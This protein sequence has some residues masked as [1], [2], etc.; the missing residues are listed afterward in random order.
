MTP[1]SFS[2]TAAEMW[3][4][5]SRSR[6]LR[7]FVSFKCISRSDLILKAEFF[8]FHKSMLMELIHFPGHLMTSW[9]NT[10]KLDCPRR[11][12]QINF[13]NGT[14]S[15]MRKEFLNGMHWKKITLGYNSSFPSGP[16][17]CDLIVRSDHVSRLGKRVYHVFSSGLYI[18]SF[19]GIPTS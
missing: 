13:L 6:S 18:L 12:S 17:S 7:Y 2:M 10:N 14:Y 4:F 8:S 11:K 5:W 16:R 15:V 19:I 9:M 3:R 1:L